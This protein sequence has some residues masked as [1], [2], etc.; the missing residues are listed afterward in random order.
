MA[1]DDDETADANE[2]MTYAWLKFYFANQSLLL[3]HSTFEK[4]F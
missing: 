3:R 4:L 2:V 1:T